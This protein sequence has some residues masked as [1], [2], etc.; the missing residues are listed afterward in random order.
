MVRRRL[1]V[2]RRATR[3]LVAVAGALVL[4]LA[5]ALVF[6]GTAAELWRTYRATAFWNR[7]IGDYAGYYFYLFLEQYPVLWSLL[8]AAT[9]YAIADRPRPA[10]FATIVFGTAFLAHSFAGNKL[11]R[12]IYYV[13]PFFFV[14]WGVALA[15]LF[16][17]MRRWLAGVTDRGLA[18]AGIRARPELLRW[19]R[20][21][22]LVAALLFLI[23]AT[24][25]ARMLA[26]Q[27]QPIGD[28]RTALWQKTRVAPQ[29]HLDSIDIVVTTDELRTLYFLGRYDVLV[30]RSRLLETGNSKEFV[31]D[32]RT[33]RPVISTAESLSLLLDCYPTGLVVSR[34]GFWRR[35][36]GIDDR[37]ADMLE[38]RTQR[39]VLPDGYGM[40]AYHWQTFVSPDAAK[41]VTPRTALD[42]HGHRN[43]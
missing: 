41:C 7:G 19:V 4:V 1:D 8:P 10:L 29:P 12:Y 11:E 33:G 21:G 13:M 32:S 2:S 31:I 42:R 36:I 26:A 28:E 30:S 25:A 18:E 5:A 34:N 40:Q 20:Q 37:A 22:V 43:G 27:L 39:I 6:S 16:P 24:P 17:T 3:V 23:L 15:G 38:A 35:D 14:I 9:L